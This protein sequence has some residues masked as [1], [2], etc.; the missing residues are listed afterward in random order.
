VGY[1]ADNGRT[2]VDAPSY[3]L[4]AGTED[5]CRP[6]AVVRD[7]QLCGGPLRAIVRLAQPCSL[8]LL[9]AALLRSLHSSLWQAQAIFAAVCVDWCSIQGLSLELHFAEPIN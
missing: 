2:P 7:R 4:V 1:A 8:G 9:P 3:D 6:G 5:A